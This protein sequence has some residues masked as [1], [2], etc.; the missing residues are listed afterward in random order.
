M[1]TT[2]L[3]E[4]AI[5]NPDSFY[6]NDTFRSLQEKMKHS[7]GWNTHLIYYGNN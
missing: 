2:Y 1:Q 7:E 4:Q 6:K 3:K 5:L